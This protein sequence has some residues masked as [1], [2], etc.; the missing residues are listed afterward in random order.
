MQFN[1]D[2]QSEQEV[3]EDTNHQYREIYLERSK[4]HSL[5]IILYTATSKEIIFAAISQK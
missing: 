1:K 3:L 5:L 4:Y 2:W